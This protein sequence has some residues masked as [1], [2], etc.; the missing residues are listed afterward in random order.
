M[1]RQLVTLD[2][3]ERKRLYDRVQASAAEQLPVIPLVAL[4]S[5]SARGRAR[6]LRP[7]ILDPT[8]YGTSTSSTGTRGASA[9]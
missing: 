2:P 5:S 1:R 3:L 7:A 6:E 4:T 8:S 9:P